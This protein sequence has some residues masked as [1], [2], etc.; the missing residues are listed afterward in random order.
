MDGSSINE[1]DGYCIEI[2]VEGNPKQGNID[3]ASLIEQLRQESRD[4]SNYIFDVIFDEGD[5]L[6]PNYH[7][8]FAEQPDGGYSIL[9]YLP[10]SALMAPVEAA[11]I[12]AS[13]KEYLDANE[14]NTSRMTVSLDGSLSAY[15]IIENNQITLFGLSDAAVKEFTNALAELSGSLREPSLLSL[16][17][18]PSDGASY[19]YGAPAAPNPADKTPARD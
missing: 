5:G 10:D 8:T 17:F 18:E 3:W 19:P 11:G 4:I 2:T 14:D 13:F 15:V 16:S 1:R 6:G 7:M 12:A 9:V